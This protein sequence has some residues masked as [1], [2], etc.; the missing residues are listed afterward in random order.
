MGTCLYRLYARPL[1]AFLASPG[2]SHSTT[3]MVFVSGNTIRAT[4]PNRSH[5]PRSSVTSDSNGRF[6]K[7]IATLLRFTPGRPPVLFA[8][9]PLEAAAASKT[10]GST[11]AAESWSLVS[12]MT[13]ASPSA[14]LTAT[15]FSP[16]SR[17]SAL[18]TPYLA[19]TAAATVSWRMNR[20]FQAARLV[21]ASLLSRSS[22]LRLKFP[23]TPPSPLK[24]SPPFAP[25]ASADGGR[26]AGRRWMSR[27]WKMLPSSSSI[28]FDA[29]SGRA[30]VMYA[31]PLLLFVALSARMNTPARLP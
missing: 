31:R 1:N 30:Y 25:I 10:P 14:I 9:A 12:A 21:P 11:P 15:S 18:L 22:R 19:A 29:F 23:S 17:R 8:F 24:F 13:C 20:E 27:P 2:S 26:L 28:A 3:A 7:S 5:S 4:P 6:F 16:L